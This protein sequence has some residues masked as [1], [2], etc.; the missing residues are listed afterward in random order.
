LTVPVPGLKGITTN[1]LEV[2]VRARPVRLVEPRPRPGV[3]AVPVPPQTRLE[4]ALVRVDDDGM[5]AVAVPG[6]CQSRGLP[7]RSLPVTLFPA[8]LTDPS[9]AELSAE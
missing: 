9:E 5:R 1:H 8:G 2:P 6:G 4:M 3:G 7:F